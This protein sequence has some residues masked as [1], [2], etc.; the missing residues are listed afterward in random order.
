M[1][2]WRLI[3]AIC[4]WIASAHCSIAVAP[5]V[6]DLWL[7]AVCEKGGGTTAAQYCRARMALAASDPHK[8]ARWAM[9]LMECEAQAALYSTEN[10]QTHWD[11]ANQILEEFRTRRKDHPR[12]SWL[13]WQAARNGFL[14]AQDALARWLGAPN[15]SATRELALQ[16][17]RAVEAKLDHLDESLK[18][19]LPLATDLPA[20]T[21][22]VPSVQLQQLRLESKLLRCES[23]LVRARCYPAE[24]PDRIAASTQIATTVQE[25][26]EWVPPTWPARNQLLVARATAKL[27][28]GTRQE[29]LRELKEIS[30][31]T[32]VDARPKTRAL[33][34]LI[35][36]LLDDRYIDIAQRSLAKLRALG[37]T[38]EVALADMRVQLALLAQVPAAQHDSAAQTIASSAKEIGRRYGDYWRNR[39]D[40]LLVEALGNRGADTSNSLGTDIV[41]AEVRQLLAAGDETAAIEKLVSASD[42]AKATERYPAALEFAKLGFALRKRGGQLEQ[43]ATHLLSLTEQVSEQSQAAALHWLAVE[44]LVEAVRQDSRN[45]QL[46]KLFTAALQSQVRVWPDSPEADRAQEWLEK[47]FVGQRRI[48]ELIESIQQRLVATKENRTAQQCLYKLLDVIVGYRTASSAANDLRWLS[49]Y[50]YRASRTVATTTQLVAVAAESLLAWPTAAGRSELQRSLRS[51]SSANLNET[52]QQIY[53]ALQ[54]LD[55]ARAGSLDTVQD[56]VKTF[57]VDKLS[58]DFKT[59]WGRYILNAIDETPFSEHTRW[60][61]VFA[62]WPELQEDSQ[63]IAEPHQ[64]TLL[65]RIASLRG[66]T[67][68]SI[69]TMNRMVDQSP[70]NGILR[71]ELAHML[72][73]QGAAGQSEALRLAQQ[74]ATGADKSDELFLSARWL[75]V[76]LLL[77]SGQSDKASEV[78]AHV[79]LTQQLSSEV[80]RKRFESVHK[81]APK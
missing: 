31:S 65:L 5:D 57:S 43:A 2:L 42:S 29:G 50:H 27:D 63:P 73:E 6:D 69:E 71:L 72:A 18:R 14:R 28:L 32:S 45:A 56:L 79:L 19:L 33:I 55:A 62:N 52:E 78:A 77:A 44:A 61:I 75:H 41:M 74:V 81:R 51:L 38:P 76:R 1:R 64:Q 47:W 21:I 49:E 59:S 80:W 37:D 54:M 46:S 58:S 60:S 16:S 13:E 48:D 70:R 17:I 66:R 10:S 35:N 30:E 23:M 20:T 22:L 25:S 3:L 36:A 15:N 34:V 7:K 24:S 4:F 67:S 11:A 40:A 8:F 39:A 12:Q 9:R 26:L 68:A 53:L